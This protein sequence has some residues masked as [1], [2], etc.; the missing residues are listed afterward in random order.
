MKEESKVALIIFDAYYYNLFALLKQFPEVFN[1]IAN[2]IAT[3]KM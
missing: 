2:F 3:W 1:L